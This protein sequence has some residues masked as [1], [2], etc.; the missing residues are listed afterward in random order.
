MSDDE[1]ADNLLTFIAAGHET[2]ALALGWTLR[3]LAEHPEIEAR[4]LDEIAQHAGAAQ[5]QPAQIAKLGF[6]R[7]VIQE[8]MRLYPPAAVVVRRAERD[9][10]LGATPIASGTTVYVPIYALHRR[11]ELWPD[12][13]RFDPDRF[14]PAAVQARHRYAY[15]PFGAGPRVCIGAGFA[16]LEAVAILATLAP[17]VRLTCPPGAR[18][19]P[20]L[21]ITLRPAGGLPMQ[22]RPRDAATLAAMGDD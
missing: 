15:L 9:V 17:A 16:M 21:R 11:A 19:R 20:V 22:A 1:V 2:T 6:T 5:V 10:T 8:A 7:Q 3:L 12:P 4:V 18:P 13:E 14:A